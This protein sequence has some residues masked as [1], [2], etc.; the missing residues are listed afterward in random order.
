MPR[1]SAPK[2]EKFVMKSR[3]GREMKIYVENGCAEG[4][5]PR[6]FVEKFPQFRKYDTKKIADSVRRVK[7]AHL[8]TVSERGQLKDKC[9]LNYFAAIFKFERSGILIL[10]ILYLFIVSIL[11]YF[12]SWE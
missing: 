11:L 4:L 6:A 7:S 2:K 10:I 12:K 5:V 8:K 9:E 1:K 3:D